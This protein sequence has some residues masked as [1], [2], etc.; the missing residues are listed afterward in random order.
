MVICPRTD[1]DMY[2]QTIAIKAAAPKLTAG[3][4]SV[5]IPAL[6]NGT[7]AINARCSTVRVGSP[8]EI[9]WAIVPIFINGVVKSKVGSKPRVTVYVPRK[10]AY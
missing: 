10:A 4:V 3:T 9:Y 8:I 5:T 6:T 7:N 2:S 1:L